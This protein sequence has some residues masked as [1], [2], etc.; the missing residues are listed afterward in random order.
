MNLT[1]LKRSKPLE[2]VTTKLS[3]TYDVILS[4][5]LGSINIKSGISLAYH[6]F[7]SNLLEYKLYFQ[8]SF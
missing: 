8:N 4:K 6:K 1:E 2:I 5:F 3:K 7:N